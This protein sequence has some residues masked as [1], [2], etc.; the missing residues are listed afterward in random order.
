MAMRILL[1]EDDRLLRDGLV[2][3]LRGA[4]HD[5]AWSGDG[6]EAADMGTRE[7]FDLVILDLMLPRLDGIEVCHRLRRARP[8]LPVL[9]L[10]AR[11]SEDDKVA[12]FGAGA[13]DY[14]T[15]P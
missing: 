14:V 15:K 9:M 13:D 12:G 3:L 2:D 11:G 5:V 8:G 10:T 6:K 4:G 1:V 7:P